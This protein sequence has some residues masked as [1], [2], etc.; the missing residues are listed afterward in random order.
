MSFRRMSEPLPPLRLID[1]IIASDA[2]HTADRLEAIASDP[3]NPLGA[4]MLREG[5]ISAF[6]APGLPTHW[7]NQA[8]G[9]S[10]AL[11]G[12][13]DRLDGW[14]RSNAINGCFEVMP[15]RHGPALA[16]ALGS[17]GYAQTRFDSVSWAV[18]QPGAPSLPV[19]TIATGA[20]MEVFLDCHIEA[21]GMPEPHRDG[22]KRNMR[23]W[24]GL[25]GWTLLLAR[26]SDM[27]AGAAVLHIRDGTAYI[28]ATATRPSA[29]GKG[30]QTALLE[31]CFQLALEAGADVIWSRALYLSQ[32]HRNMLRSGLRTLC[33]PAFWTRVNAVTPPRPA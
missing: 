31:R 3:G 2:A 29:R 21:W 24:L 18:P 14:L 26:I 12:E 15:D 1:R 28:A 4:V 19:E 23:R 27:P 25:P 32:S 33:T 13:V 8:M 30:A 5:P 17:A 10:K 7:L 22:A 20:G 9:F 6:G 16:T 11:A